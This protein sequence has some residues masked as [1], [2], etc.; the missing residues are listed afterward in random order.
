MRR[1]PADHVLGMKRLIMV[2]RG[3]G[4]EKAPM[5][6]CR[7]RRCCGDRGGERRASLRRD[8]KT[9]GTVFFLGAR[10]AFAKPWPIGASGRT[11]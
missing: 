3:F 11:S 6:R 8:G 10:E 9:S 5:C 2:Q 4:P 1:N 7:S